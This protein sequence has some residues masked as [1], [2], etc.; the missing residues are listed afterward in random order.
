MQVSKAYISCL[1]EEATKIFKEDMDSA[2]FNLDIIKEGKD[3]L[4][5]L[6]ESK[7]KK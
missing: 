2:T 5:K 6:T 3:L 4:R 1:D 7:E